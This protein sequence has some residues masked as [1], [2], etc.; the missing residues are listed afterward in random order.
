MNFGFLYIGFIY[1]AMLFIVNLFLA[2]KSE[3]DDEYVNNK[4]EAMHVFKNWL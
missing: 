4:R 2:K 3:N 1:L